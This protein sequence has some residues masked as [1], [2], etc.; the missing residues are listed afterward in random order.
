MDYQARR[1]QRELHLG[2]D[3]LIVARREL[4][5]LR[6]DVYVLACAVEDVDRDL[7]SRP[8]AREVRTALEW[9]LDAARPLCA[10]DL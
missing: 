2:D 3:E 7:A 5:Q 1:R 9:L 6:D 8:T 10:R 4:D